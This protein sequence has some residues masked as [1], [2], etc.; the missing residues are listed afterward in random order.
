MVH[1]AGRSPTGCCC[2]RIR[3]GRRRAMAPKLGGA[4]VLDAAMGDSAA[5][6]VLFGSVAGAVGS[7]GQAAYAAANAALAAVAAAA[8]GG[9][10][11]AGGADRLGPG[12]AGWRRGWWGRGRRTRWGGDAR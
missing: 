9:G 5:T 3:R 6:L 7:P 8:A 1:A 4:E 11:A 10:R 2:G 12:R